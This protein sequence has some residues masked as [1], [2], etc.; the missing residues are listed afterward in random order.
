[1]IDDCED[2]DD[3]DL[4]NCI[5]FEG[6]N[7]YAAIKQKS[8]NNDTRGSTEM[9]NGCVCMCRTVWICVRDEMIQKKKR[10]KQNKL[11]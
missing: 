9:D 10:E 5:A 11:E 4:N 7:V 3:D 1:M 8:A 6:M 2:V